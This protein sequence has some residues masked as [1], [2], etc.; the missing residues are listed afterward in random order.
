MQDK[1]SFK[2]IRVYDD[3][4]H[5]PSEIS[6]SIKAFKNLIKNDNRLIIIFQPHTY[7][8]TSALYDEFAKVFS[9]LDYLI[10]IDI[11]AAREDNVA[12]VNSKDLVEYI[13]NKYNKNFI[14]IETMEETVKFLIDFL[15]PNDVVVSMGA[16]DVFKITN[17]LIKKL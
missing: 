16:G 5:H 8:R 9:T 4:A 1:G 10:L 17:E 11:Y 2:N 13:N 14:Y 15:K 12:G 6:A 3:Y 7:T